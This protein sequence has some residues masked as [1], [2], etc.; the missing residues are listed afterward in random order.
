MMKPD[1]TQPYWNVCRRVYLAWAVIVL[2]GF[3]TTHFHQ[4]PDINY[5]WLFL[6]IIGLGYMGWLLKRIGFKNAQLRNI[7]FL[8]LFTIVFGLA[9]SFSAFYYRP[10]AELTGILGIFW[11]FLLGIAHVFNSAIDRSRLYWLTGGAQIVAGSL[12]LVLTPLQGIQYL[13]TGLMSGLAM[14]VLFLFR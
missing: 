12:C 2:V 14:M 7:L 4:R 6:S 1:T 8:W 11:L 3:I 13:M 10:F 5:L 9:L